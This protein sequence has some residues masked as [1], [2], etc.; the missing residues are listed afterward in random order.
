VP[1]GVASLGKRGRTQGADA[2]GA[3]PVIR[4][5]GYVICLDAADRQSASR[6]DLGH[7]AQSIWQ[8]N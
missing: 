1:Q 8:A 7:A 5:G 3:D 6:S 2:G 4:H